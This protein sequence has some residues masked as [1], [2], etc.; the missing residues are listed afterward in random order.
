MIWNPDKAKIQ[1]SIAAAQ[2]DQKAPPPKPLWRRGVQ[3]GAHLIQNNVIAYSRADGAIGGLRPATQG[4]NLYWEKFLGDAVDYATRF[5]NEPETIAA[6]GLEDKTLVLGDTQESEYFTRVE[7]C[8]VVKVRGFASAIP[9]RGGYVHVFVAK[10]GKIIHVNSTLRPGKKPLTLGKI[11]TQEQAIELAQAKLGV[12][13]CGVANCKLVLSSHEENLDP[14]YEV[15]L[16]VCKPRQ[17]RMFLVKASNGGEVV[18]DENKLIHMKAHTLAKTG[19]SGQ[20]GKQRKTKKPRQSGQHK[21][22][23]TKDAGGIAA[24]SFLRFPTFDQNNPIPKEVVKVMIDRAELPDPTVL[25]NRRYTMHVLNNGKWEV[26]KANSR[27]TFE[28]DPFNGDPA[29]LTKFSAVL[30]FI[31]L[32]TQHAEIEKLGGGIIA[33]SLPVF[34]DDPD[35]SDNAF[36]DPELIQVRTGKGSGT[37]HG[38]LIEEIAAD[39]SVI[40]H[41]D[42]HYWN[43]LLAPGKDLPGRQGRGAGEATADCFGALRSDFW[44][45]LINGTALGHTLTLQDIIDGDGV[46][47][48]L[49]G[50]PNGLR[51][52]NNSKHYPEDIVNEE[53][54]DGLIIGGAFFD[55]LKAMAKVPGAEVESLLKTYLKLYINGTRLLPAHKVLFSDYVPAFLTADNVITGGANQS[56]IEQAFAKR[57][58]KA[59]AGP[60]APPTRRRSR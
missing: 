36:Y 46:I 28:F 39:P 22:A 20:P 10:D 6:L 13:T 5:T 55:L 52:Q 54:E 25:A 29:E 35:I 16:S 45:R 27:G 51:S 24:N 57:G 30:S 23:S 1:A 26:L 37:R 47:G 53:H 60:T 43:A 4:T 14:V 31:W 18:Y 15:L 32:N 58:I 49:A 50:G 59:P 11:I 7:F 40:T 42:I 56:L 2:T 3:Q 38:G 12:E 44:M 21:K 17:L 41:E 33:D 8:Q 34:I 9:V 48:K 19:R